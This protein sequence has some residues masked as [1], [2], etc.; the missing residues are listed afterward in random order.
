MKMK[1][2]LGKYFTWYYVLIIVLGIYSTFLTIFRFRTFAES[3]E[4]FLNSGFS[5]IT[6]ISS[7]LSLIAFISSI[8]LLFVVRK[9]KLQ[10]FFYF[11]PSYYIFYYFIW[12]FLLSIFM[13]LIY[14]AMDGINVLSRFDIVFFIL[15]IVIP[16]YSLYRLKKK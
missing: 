11:C 15:N 2:K 13:G 7:G 10:K 1:E 3:Y 4:A 14:G 9:N 5:F 16:S 12:S 8:I 6:Y